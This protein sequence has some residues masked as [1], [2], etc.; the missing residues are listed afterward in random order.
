MRKLNR[1]STYRCFYR[2]ISNFNEGNDYGWKARDLREKRDLALKYM[3]DVRLRTPIHESIRKKISLNHAFLKDIDLSSLLQT[4]EPP[5]K[6]LDS[7]GFD[8]CLE[9][10]LNFD[11]H[12]EETMNFVSKMDLP[13]LND[14]FIVNSSAQEATVRNWLKI[15]NETSDYHNYASIPEN[16]RTSWSAWYLRNVKPPPNS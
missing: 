8:D 14:E 6:E 15:R 13:L 5:K 12:F 9:D 3:S 4:N 2:S 10:I 16:E 7:L 11:E 1:S